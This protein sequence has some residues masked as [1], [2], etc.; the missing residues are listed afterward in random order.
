MSLF[1]S[2]ATLFTGLQKPLEYSYCLLMSRVQYFFW[3]IPMHNNIA[4]KLDNQLTEV[5]KIFLTLTRYLPLFHDIQVT[6]YHVITLA[7]L[8]FVI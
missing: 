3:F 8:A 2:E 7:T 4:K 6:Y 5:I 1:E